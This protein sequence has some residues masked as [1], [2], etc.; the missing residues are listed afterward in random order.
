MSLKFLFIILAALLIASVGIISFAAGEGLVDVKILPGTFWY[1]FKLLWEDIVT[2]FTFND[3]TLAN[4]YLDLAEERLAEIKKLETMKNYEQVKKTLVRYQEK[5]QRAKETIAA[6][7]RAGED[8]E[9][10]I[11][12]GVEFVDANRDTLQGVYNNAPDEL[13]RLAKDT[14]DKTELSK[15]DWLNALKNQMQDQLFNQGKE[16]NKNLKQLNNDFKEG[17]VPNIPNLKNIITQ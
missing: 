16:N 10:V 7:K 1:P 3:L 12:K 8:V 5:L 13:K 2:L 4:R 6:A 11:N 9:G 14:L 15:K 17:I